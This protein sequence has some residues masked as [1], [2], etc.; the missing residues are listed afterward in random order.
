MFIKQPSIGV[1]CNIIST[2]KGTTFHKVTLGTVAETIELLEKQ[3]ANAQ[4][5]ITYNPE[6][7][8]EMSNDAGKKWTSYQG[9]LTFYVPKS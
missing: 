8:K 3:D 4:V 9:N 1:W 5:Q 6:Q 7:A 2:S